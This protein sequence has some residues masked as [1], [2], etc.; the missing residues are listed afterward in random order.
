M[1]L[2]FDP[3][4]NFS[5]LQAICEQFAAAAPEFVRLSE[6][7]R[8]REG[9]PLLLLTVTDFSTGDPK[10]KPGIL[11]QSNIHCHELA[12]PLAAL[13]TVQRLVENRDQDGILKNTVYYVLPRINPDY[14]E[15]VIEHSGWIRSRRDDRD[16]RP[17]TFHQEETVSFCE[18]ARSVRTEICASTRTIC[19][20]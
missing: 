16:E 9:R 19:N 4:L 5:K 3:F 15:R 6:I 17:N 2:S 11:I 8:S 14:A 18:Y 12:G 1:E 7:G 10:D 20:G 13:H